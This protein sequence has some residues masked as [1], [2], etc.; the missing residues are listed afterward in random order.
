VF[1]NKKIIQVGIQGSERIEGRWGK[2][3]TGSQM[4][5]THAPAARID[6]T[7]QG[8]KYGNLKVHVIKVLSYGLNDAKNISLKQYA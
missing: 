3:H 6:M 1:P 8:R 2:G 4:H 5:A 7:R